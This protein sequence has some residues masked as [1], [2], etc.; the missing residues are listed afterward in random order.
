[1]LNF[2]RSQR[3]TL[4]QERDGFQA[5]L[6][7]I[8]EAAESEKRSAL[9]TEELSKFDELR[10]SISEKDEEIRKMDERITEAEEREARSSRESEVRKELGQVGEKSGEVRSGVRVGSEPTTY[11]KDGR[12][13][14]F[15]DLI[16]VNLNRPDSRSAMDRLQRNQQEVAVESRALS[17]TDGAGGDFVPPLWMI[18][19]Y[20]ELARTARPTADRV[21]NEV[22]PSGT[23]QV[24]VPKIVTGTAVAEQAT[25]NTAVQNTDATTGSV[26]ANVATLAGQQ[27]IPVQLI[28]QSPLNMDTILLADLAADY[29]AKVDL[30]VLNNNATNKKGL[31]QETGTNAATYTSGT[32]T[33]GG[34]YSQLANAI[35]LVT[36]NRFLPPDTIVMHP[37]RWAWMLAAVDTN[38][39]PL[40][41]PSANG[42]AF[43]ALGAMSGVAG[44][45]G[46][47]GNLAGL[48][49]IVDP[50]IPTNLGAGTNQD[51]VIVFRASDSILWEGAPHAEAFRETKADQL[52]VLLRF[53][54]YAAFTA[55]RYAKS[56][57]VINGT[58]L[59]APT[60]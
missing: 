50:Q 32:P 48:D 37:R 15:R 6:D 57:S 9:T 45:N 44:V 14:Y 12:E 8:V 39:R 18:N 21:R 54:R 23:D 33:V 34:F 2:L 58:G 10:A 55:A 46:V 56:V 47:V 26:A 1:M 20:V 28:E 24:N 16:A 59:V 25:Q 31:L 27:V 38:N 52:S 22:L 17:T 53:Y 3:D 35:Q 42:Q 43:N 40:V 41:L 13:S 51:P 60:F 4:Q 5:N 36:T 29:A 11:R 49:V 30:F 19:D 7:G